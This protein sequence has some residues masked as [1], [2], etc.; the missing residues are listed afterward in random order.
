[1]LHANERVGTSIYIYLVYM[2]YKKHTVCT[3]GA[4]SLSCAVRWRGD[5]T[6][7]WWF[8]DIIVMVVIFSAIREASKERIVVHFSSKS[9]PCCLSFCYSLLLLYAHGLLF[10]VVCLWSM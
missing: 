10:V 8:K 3:S 1:M 9:L 5:N 6:T 4:A 2:I 7:N